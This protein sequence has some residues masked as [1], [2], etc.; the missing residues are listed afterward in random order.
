MIIATLIIFFYLAIIIGSI[1]LWAIN[2]R[3]KEKKREEKEHK[4]YK[5]Y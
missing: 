4:D 2:D 5:K 3:I 1:G